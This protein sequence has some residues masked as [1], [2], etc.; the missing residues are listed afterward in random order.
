M[1]K[2]F[3]AGAFALFGL[4]NAQEKGNF[5]VGAHIGLPVGDLSNT[6]SFN[7]GADVAYVY[8]VSENLKLGVTTGY[9]HYFGKR[10]RVGLGD[11]NFS[12]DFPDLG[13][14]PLA[15]TG[16]V[17]V[18]N[19]IFVGADLGYAFFAGRYSDFKTGSFY[20][21][22]KVGYSVNGKHDVYL[23]FKGMS[24]KY[25]GVRDNGNSINLGYDY[26]F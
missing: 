17:N 24:F 15:A 26:N 16:Q 19:N 3:L 8:P 11:F 20:Y 5:K 18:G 6:H 25:Q 13:I 1:K 21:Q 9:S 4:V 12:F 23:S 7:I 22:P 14:I 10:E 2:M